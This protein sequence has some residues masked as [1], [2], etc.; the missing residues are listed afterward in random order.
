MTNQVI[1]DTIIGHIKKKNFLPV[2]SQT[3][4]DFNGTDTK[5]LFEENLL[6]QPKD[7]YYRT[8]EVVYT[9]NEQGYRTKD[10]KNV[11][12]ANSIVIFGCSNVAGFG[13]TDDD[14]V[15][16]QLEKMTGIPVINMGVGG[17]SNEFSLFNSVILSQNYP[18]PLGVVHIWTGTDRT[19]Y[20][21]KN[22][23]TAYGS[24]NFEENNYFDLFTRDQYHG[25]VHSLFCGMIS[26]QLWIEKTKFYHASFFYP[27]AKINDCDY[28]AFSDHGRDFV[29][30]GRLTWKKVAEKIKEEFK[31]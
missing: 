20:F 27:T 15:S 24:W 23:T 21:H 16:S 9:F 29:H 8:N 19:I 25:Q 14:T 7:W 4:T 11:D 12:W 22:S 31:L 28:L 6:K 1:S 5:N 10:F 13:V 18:T 26:Q 17:S 30:P 3:N 2:H